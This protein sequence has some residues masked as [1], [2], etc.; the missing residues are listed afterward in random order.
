MSKF[1]NILNRLNID[2]TLTKRIHAEPKTG[3]NSI[4]DN[5]PLIA[6][7]NMMADLLFLPTAQYGYKYLFV[8][9]DLATNKFDIEQMKNK[10]AQSCLNAMLKCFKRGIIKQPYASLKTDDGNEFKGIFQKY[11]YDESILHKTALP[12]RHKSMANVES[13]NKQLAR[14]IMGYLNTIEKQKGKTF[15]NWLGAIPII[16]EDLNIARENK[17]LPNN[18]YTHKYPAFDNYISSSKKGKIKESF[19]QPK[20]KVG[21]MVHRA[22]D[23]PQTALGKNQNTKSFRSG[24]YTF[25]NEPREIIKIVYYAGKGPS[26][27]YLLDG[28]KNASYVA[29]EL[30]K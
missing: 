7:Y 4:K 18:I 5:I 17:N 11:L 16:R 15:N 27:R 21:D 3:F 22:L 13:L 20:F 12:N 10:D 9:V 8:I 26:Y 25:E 24:D 6:D 19:Q 29:N 30:K 23:T 14:L 1:R 2:E 28:I